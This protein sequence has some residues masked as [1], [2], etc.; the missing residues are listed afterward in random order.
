MSASRLL[1]KIFVLIYFSITERENMFLRNIITLNKQQKTY[2]FYISS[3][4]IGIFLGTTDYVIFNDIA[5][6]IV[7]I[8]I[9]LF[10]F[11]S[12]PLISLSLI[13]SLSKCIP[14]QGMIRL[15]K[16]TVFYTIL[17]TM[18]A[19][20]LALL[21]YKII[22]PSNIIIKP[23]NTVAMGK[24]S[25]L[26]HLVNLIPNNFLSPF[27]ENQVM[28][29]L[30]ISGSIGIAIHFITDKNIKNNV[31]IFFEG[32]HSISLTITRWIMR[33]IPIA[34]SGFVAVTILQFKQ[35]LNISGLGEYLSIIILSNLIQGIVILPII[36]YINGHNPLKIIK[37]MFP[38]L[39][40]AF[41]SKSSTGTLPATMR[42]AEQNLNVSPQVSR[43][44]LPFCTSINMNGC[45]AFI[46]I[47]V[48]YVMQNNG[49]EMSLGNMFSWVLVATISALGNAGVPMGCFFLSAS[50][51]TNMGIPI[52]IM[53]IILP[54]YSIVDMLETSLNVWSDSC[55]TVIV[56][57]DYSD[58][59]HQN[60]N[61]IEQS[62]VEQ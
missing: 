43:S 27:L 11:I 31:I 32:M 7:N 8:F 40:I 18:L 45:A 29:V 20:S 17:T 49:I 2:F 61:S 42:C 10:K 21:I 30:L 41:F 51:L 9:R 34:M 54:F 53:S 24:I 38:A 1:K 28:G 55:V 19:A 48:V 4:L 62:G 58:S 57:K 3:I 15:W 47:T 33:I 26:Q 5:E 6:V 37:G 46:L 25:Y 13:V 22:S 44:I 23:D 39:V 12:L 36:L 59:S 50:L 14:E 52:N 60:N 16:R 35:G 56:N